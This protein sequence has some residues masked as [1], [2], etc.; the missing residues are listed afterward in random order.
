MSAPSADRVHTLVLAGPLPPPYS[1]QSLSFAMLTEAVAERAIDH[2]VVNIG[3][4]RGSSARAGRV[5]D[6][7]GIFAR[8]GRAVATGRGTVYLTIAQSRDGF[9]RDLVMIR[10]ARLSGYRVVVHLKGGNYDTFY[11][12]Q[13][14]VLR[15]LIRATLR[16]C[17][18][19]LVLGER[20]RAMYDFEP[21]LASRI[22]VVANG[23]PQRA[24]PAIAPKK[25]PAAGEAPMRLLFLSN[26]IESKG[27]IDVLDAMRLLR[28]RYGRGRVR[29]DFYGE[30]MRNAADDVR[31][32][33][34]EQAREL[35][36]E[37]IASHQLAD[38]VSWHGTISGDAKRAAL[39]ESHVFLLPT[40]YNNEGQPVS[41]IEAMA[42]ANVVVAT[43]Y[44][45]I[46]DLV[47]DGVTGI[48]V[49]YGD[50]VALAASIAALLVDPVRFA[51]M[52]RAARERYE[53]RFTRE[54]HLAQLLPHLLG[55]PSD[56]GTAPA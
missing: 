53:R 27:W 25:L 21:A 20:L 56:A 32:S 38:A 36:N 16:S 4:A 8:F 19:V 12:G 18:R 10:L 15:R 39:R 55:T 43:D 9:L 6:F 3:S 14:P 31:V 46:P 7:V 2:R 40:R 42:Y 51:S 33:G 22:H 5:R 13:G 26:L 49:P 28:D 52:S 34:A 45:A 17:D 23:L 41:I 35:F 29:C 48:L 11:A 44:R 24:R 50:P 37:L 1:G 30:F 54:A 47:V